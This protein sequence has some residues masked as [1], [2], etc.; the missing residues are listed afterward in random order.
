MLLFQSTAADTLIIL[1]AKTAMYATLDNS[2]DLST[3]LIRGAMNI[4]NALIPHTAAVPDPIPMMETPQEKAAR[5]ALEENAVYSPEETA[6][7]SAL[8]KA[9]Q[10]AMRAKEEDLVS[11]KYL[12]I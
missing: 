12:I 4:L 1:K 3:R 2:L 11:A 9:K 10:R 8:S 7:Y 6:F 5:E